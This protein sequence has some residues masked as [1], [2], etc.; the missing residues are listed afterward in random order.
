MDLESLRIKLISIA[1]L[2]SGSDSQDEAL[3]E[4]V[5]LIEALGDSA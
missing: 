5:L 4:I 2:L 1:S 3:E